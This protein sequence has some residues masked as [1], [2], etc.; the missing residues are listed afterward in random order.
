MSDARIPWSEEAEQTLGCAIVHGRMD[1]LDGLRP[2]H[3]FDPAYGTLYAAALALHE[4]GETVNPITLHRVLKDN[5]AFADMGGKAWV[6]K[7]AAIVPPPGLLSET[8]KVVRDGA[9]RRG[10]VELAE[11]IRTRATSG[12]LTGAD[13]IVREA[14]EAL[15]K[16]G[17]DG[18]TAAQPKAIA[19]I[20]GGYLE[21]IE[22]AMKHRGEVTGVTTGIREL[23]ACISGFQPTDLIILAGRPAM[24]K[25]ALAINRWAVSAAMAGKRTLVLN[26][27]MGAEQ[28]LGRMVSAATGIDGQKQR[29]GQVDQHDW[30]AL[31]DATRRLSSLPLHI[32][33][34]PPH[35][36]AGLRTLVR[37]QKRRFGLDLLIIDYLQLMRD[38]KRRNGD[39]R[40]NELSEITRLLKALAKELAIP[41][42]ALS[43]L[44]R[45]VEQ[46][47]DKRPQ[48][49]DL[50]ESGSIEQDADIV[51]FV[52]RE[53]YYLTRAEPEAGTDKWAQWRARLD[54]VEGRGEIIVA[55]HRHGPTSTIHAHWDGPRQLFS[56]L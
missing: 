51:M 48:L 17:E 4:R 38:D 56:D 19:E 49:A 25:S 1:A 23:D 2:E 15:Y 12:G 47:D 29:N 34:R 53:E 14:E 46:R 50:R 36:M 10:L 18:T 37:R 35:S 3:F 42:I 5:P 55:K 8:I 52:Y 45:A 31:F 16:L 43:Q 44:S 40:M 30:D 41:V 13:V 24:G 11:S 27:E 54:Q 39:N 28:L 32:E 33:E 6:A 7:L 20:A 21:N 26:Y 9:T 22:R